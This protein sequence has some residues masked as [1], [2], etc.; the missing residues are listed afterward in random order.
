VTT[1][2]KKK[3]NEREKC[4]RINEKLVCGFQIVVM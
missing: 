3:Q 1:T 2:T 4:E